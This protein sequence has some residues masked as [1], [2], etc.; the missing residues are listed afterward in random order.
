[1][2]VHGLPADRHSLCRNG[3]GVAKAAEEL[4]RGAAREALG[5]LLD[6]ACARLG[7][8]VKRAFD[9]AAEQSQLQR[10]SGKL[11]S[12][13]SRTECRIPPGCWVLVTPLLACSILSLL[14]SSL[15]PAEYE[16]L[17]PY[18]A[19]HAALRSAFQAFV[20]GLEDRCRGIVRHHLE[21]ATSEY[22]IQQLAGGWIAE[23]TREFQGWKGRHTGGPARAMHARLAFCVWRLVRGLRLHVGLSCT[24]TAFCAAHAPQTHTKLMM[25]PRSMRARLDQTRTS[26]RGLWA[27]CRLQRHS[28][29]GNWRALGPIQVAGAHGTVVLQGNTQL[30]CARS[31]AQPC[32]RSCSPPLPDCA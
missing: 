10:G 31:L 9:I 1:M 14:L 6:A 25:C 2:F 18:V 26:R 23:H 24:G 17:R 28:R 19:F 7:A 15:L 29:C 20:A 8:V 11:G 13:I 22:A 21:T 30:S 12:A 32:H 16:R 3:G 5:P 4:A 27:A